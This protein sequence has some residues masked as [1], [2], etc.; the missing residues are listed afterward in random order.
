MLQTTAPPSRLSAT[1]ARA[2]KL[3][4]SSWVECRATTT[5]REDIM[6]GTPCAPNIA[7]PVHGYAAQQ[8]QVVRTTLGRLGLLINS[9]GGLPGRKALLYVS[10]G[11]PQQPGADLFEVLNQMC[12]GGAAT[13]GVGYT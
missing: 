6:L 13:S 9:L 8:R 7:D 11:I 2:S 10:D 1:T 3:E 5:R 12:G 4:A